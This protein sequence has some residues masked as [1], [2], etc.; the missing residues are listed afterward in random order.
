MDLGE[1]YDRVRNGVELNATD[2]IRFF[3]PHSDSGTATLSQ[4]VPDTITTWIVSAF[5]M[6]EQAGLGVPSSTTSVRTPLVFFNFVETFFSRI[7]KIFQAVF[8]IA[9]SSLFRYSRRTI[10]PESCRL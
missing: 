8:C 5:A 10:G 1:R 2:N 3:P 9:G 6:N 7:A 4:I